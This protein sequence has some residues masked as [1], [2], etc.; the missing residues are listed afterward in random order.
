[1][2]G[3]HRE[4]FEKQASDNK[5]AAREREDQG[6]IPDMKVQHMVWDKSSSV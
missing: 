4:G 3:T 6:K 1:M 5:K 2:P